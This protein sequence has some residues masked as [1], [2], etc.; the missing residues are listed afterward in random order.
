MRSAERLL[1]AIAIGAVLISASA[2]AGGPLSLVQQQRYCMGT[3]FSITVYHASSREAAQ[4][5]ERAMAE[6]VR[7]DSVMSHFK[8]ESDL[9]RLNRDASRGPVRVDPS[10]HDVI[11]R[12]ILFS[13]RSAGKFDVTIGALLQVWQDARES[14]RPP[15]SAEIADASR[16]VGYR[17]IEIGAD[18][19][20]RFRSD[21]LRLDLGGI[22]KGYAVDRALD[23]L[24]ASGVR[25]ALVNAGGSSIGSIGAPPDAEGWP[26]RLRENAADHTVLLRNNSIS[27]SQQDL[28]SLTFA[29][30]QFGHIIDPQRGAPALQR[31]AI[32]VVAP[33]ATTADALSTALVTMTPDEGRALLEQFSNVAAFWISPAGVVRTYRTSAIELADHR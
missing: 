20:I 3:M 23:V 21:C 2:L 10:L 12:S 27:T 18:H 1:S 30:G 32:S 22:G 7:L 6:I 9:S 17:H 11:E 13:E 31:T 28:V 16:C 14:G 33:D 15:T 5:I 29:G 25:H 24:Q 19:R 26:V 8:A 4:A